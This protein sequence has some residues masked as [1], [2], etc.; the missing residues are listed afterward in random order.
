MQE[1]FHLPVNGQGLF[2]AVPF[3]AAESRTRNQI[4]IKFEI[5]VVALSKRLPSGWVMRR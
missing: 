2:F 3:D 1:F 4:T 5:F